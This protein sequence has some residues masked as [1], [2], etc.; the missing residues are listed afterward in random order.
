MVVIL[1]TLPPSHLVSEDYRGSGGNELLENYFYWQSRDG[2]E[3]V[4]VSH[5]THP[6]TS[7]SSIGTVVPEKCT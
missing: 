6:V 5:H 1:A 3:R 2:I 7:Y 4:Y